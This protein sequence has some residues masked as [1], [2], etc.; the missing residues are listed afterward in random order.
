MNLGSKYVVVAVFFFP[1]LRL[2][3]RKSGKIFATFSCFFFLSFFPS[4]SLLSKNK[5]KIT[6]KHQ[7]KSNFEQC[8]RWKCSNDEKSKFKIEKTNFNLKPKKTNSPQTRAN[9]IKVDASNLFDQ[10]IRLRNKHLFAE[11]ERERK[12]KIFVN[13]FF[14]CKLARQRKWISKVRL[15]F[16]F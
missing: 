8:K 12:I 5:T 10:A 14:L 1:T 2:T 11:E 3:Q 16:Y 9:Q 15:C 6:E 7:I 13:Q 4:L